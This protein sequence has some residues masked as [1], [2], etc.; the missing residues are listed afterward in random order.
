MGPF[1]ERTTEVTYTLLS[2]KSL[3]DPQ[4]FSPYV[5]KGSSMRKHQKE[6]AFSDL[7]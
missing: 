1:D 2:S 5:R 7:G 4:C 6:A 3:R